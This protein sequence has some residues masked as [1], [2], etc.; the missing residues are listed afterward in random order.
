MLE[1]IRDG[2]KVKAIIL[3][4]SH[5]P[6]VDFGGETL[7]G[8]IGT[9][10]V[11]RH[12][13]RRLAEK[14]VA[15]LGF[16]PDVRVDLVEQVQGLSPQDKNGVVP[17]DRRGESI[18]VD[19]MSQFG[20]LK[21]LPPARTERAEAISSTPPSRTVGMSRPAHHADGPRRSRPGRWAGPVRRRTSRCGAVPRGRWPWSCW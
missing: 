2:R 17:P 16:D 18:V 1:F 4:G 19:P 14:S 9:K 15:W 20:D 8:L 10:I 12:R 5:D 3:L 13:N 6:E 21:I 7:S 11:M